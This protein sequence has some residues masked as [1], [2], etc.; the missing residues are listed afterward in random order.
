M[1]TVSTYQELIARQRADQSDA[2]LMSVRRL[3]WSAERLA[4][5]RE[6]RLRELLQ[7]SFDHSDFWRERLAGHDLSEFTEADLPSLPI[8]TKKELM[9]NFDRIVTNPNLSLERLNEHVNHLES[10]TYVDDEYRAVITSGTGGVRGLFVYGWSEWITY[11]LIATRWRT[12]SGEDPFAPV[13]TFF[14]INTKHVS[15]A[16]H[17]FSQ[18]FAGHGPLA[19]T[20]LPATLPI[21][22]IVDGLN[23]A[24]PTVLTGYASVIHLLALEALAGRLTIQPNWVAT[25]GEQ[26]T[27]EVK[28][29][30]RS[31]WGIEIYDTWGCTEG[32]FA[33]PC[34]PGRPM[35]LPDD[36]AIIE[37]VDENNN[38]VPYG[39]P[40]AKI[41]LT[42]LYNKTQP[43]I[44]YEINDSMTMIDEPCECG[45]AHRRITDIRGRLDAF[46]RYENGTIIHS[47][48]V[49][50]IVLGDPNVVE[51]QVTQTHNGMV[52][53][54]V[55]QGESDNEALRDNLV[56]L[57]TRAGLNEPDV[58]VV[59]V[60]SLE[61]MW[62]GKLRQY[63]PLPR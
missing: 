18:D 24:R 52:V 50:G 8:L 46:F 6:R 31:A 41:L 25:N 4:A 28:R 22:E 59:N 53:S 12:R 51:M 61:R 20:H 60:D 48:G 10:D 45:C 16:L 38:P 27:D 36:L 54:L 32:V 42:N 15:G 13:G 56:E 37:P 29:A 39:Q 17:A 33:C 26:L 21:P 14:A 34:A 2:F 23:A 49:N 35:H 44:R 7:W 9:A 3:S 43:L 11:A 47:V 30:V 63:E 55:T 62:S 57:L 1:E 19:V 5:E 58:A 40:A